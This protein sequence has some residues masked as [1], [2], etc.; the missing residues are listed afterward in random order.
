MLHPPR[1]GTQERGRPGKEQHP[2]LSGERELNARS[3]WH[4]APGP[5]FLLS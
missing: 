1:G 2:L 5:F 4:Q 3:I